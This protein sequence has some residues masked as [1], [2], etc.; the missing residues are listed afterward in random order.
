MV[1]ISIVAEVEEGEEEEAAGE[2]GGGSS[3]AIQKHAFADTIRIRRYHRDHAS[4]EDD[5][6]V[7]GAECRIGE[8][9]RRWRCRRRYYCRWRE[10]AEDELFTVGAGLAYGRADM[11]TV[12]RMSRFNLGVLQQESSGNRLSRLTT[13]GSN[14]GNTNHEWNLG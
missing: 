2:G 3:I 10:F 14:A 6:C 11:T 13:G 8:R 12:N 5:D 4:L 9:K 7:Q 1:G